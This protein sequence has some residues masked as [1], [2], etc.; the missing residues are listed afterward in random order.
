MPA[1]G[2]NDRKFSKK[3]R[4]ALA[5]L[6]ERFPDNDPR[7]PGSQTDIGYTIRTMGF[8]FE[9]KKMKNASGISIAIPMS[10]QCPRP[11]LKSLISD[12]NVNLFQSK[13]N[14]HR[15]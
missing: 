14:T 10:L 7:K 2:S 1:I 8:D 5:Q 12:T 13:G 11:V 4:I 9:R 15:K 3:A 6:G